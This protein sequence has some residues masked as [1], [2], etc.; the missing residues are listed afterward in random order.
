[1]RPKKAHKP[2]TLYQKETQAGPVWYARFWNETAMRYA[3]TRSTG[4]PV[5]GK[6]QR[7][8]EA[9]EA[10]RKILPRTVCAAACGKDI[11]PIPG[12][13][14]GTRFLLYQGSRISQKKALIRLLH[15]HES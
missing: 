7:R 1:M 15:T 9:E 8:Y 10:A 2:F 6:R 11:H 13:I 4:V 3:V 12:R 14:L 5:E